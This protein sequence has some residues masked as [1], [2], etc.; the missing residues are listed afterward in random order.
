[1]ER[2]FKQGSTSVCDDERLG[3]PSTSTIENNVQVIEGTVMV[4]CGPRAIRYHPSE[5]VR[6]I[7]QT[8]CR[9]VL[10]NTVESQKLSTR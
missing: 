8:P 5:F 4:I 9:A 3:S 6:R 10:C 2:H 7:P 1:M